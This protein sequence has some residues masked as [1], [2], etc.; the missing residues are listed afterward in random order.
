MH[1]I[2]VIF[3]LAEVGGAERIVSL[4]ANYWAE[5]GWAVTIMI[6]KMSQTFPRY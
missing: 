3:S 4:M 5:K 6:L 2:F 1:V